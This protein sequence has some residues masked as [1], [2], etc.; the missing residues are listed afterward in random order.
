M[1]KKVI[2]NI[3]GSAVKIFWDQNDIKEGWKAQRQLVHSKWCRAGD[4]TVISEKAELQ[5][6]SKVFAETWKKLN[7]PQTGENNKEITEQM[8]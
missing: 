5:R 2:K 3:P 8:N 6:N 4:E 7:K 1:L